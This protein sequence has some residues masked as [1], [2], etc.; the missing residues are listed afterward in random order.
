MKVLINESD[1]LVTGCSCLLVHDPKNQFLSA[2]TAVPSMKLVLAQTQGD[3]AEAIAEMEKRISDFD[4]DVLDCEKVSAEDS[5][6][7]SDADYIYVQATLNELKA[8]KAS[9]R[10]YLRLHSPK[11]NLGTNLLLEPRKLGYNFPG[12]IATD[13]NQLISFL[14]ATP[15]MVE[16]ALWHQA[17]IYG[18]D[19]YL[20][21]LTFRM[22]YAE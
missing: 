7:F 6:V 10:I 14:A 2:V 17:E 20:H 3:V 11:A 16:P 19:R 1:G 21:Q 4:H 13:D 9:E 18:E 15:S 5:I 22:P 8:C 12:W